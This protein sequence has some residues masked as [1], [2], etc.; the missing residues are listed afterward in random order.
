MQ[1][2]ITRFVSLLGSSLILLLSIKL[3]TPD[4][5][6]TYIVNLGLASLF[7]WLADFGLG[8]LALMS[9]SR[10]EASQF[11]VLLGLKF[12]SF[13]FL[14]SIT[15]FILNFAGLPKFESVIYI[16]MAV[17]VMT[18]TLVSVRQITCDWRTGF[19]IQA[20]KKISQ[21]ALLF[22]FFVDKSG[23]TL[24]S[25][26]MIILLPSLLIILFDVAHL[27]P[28]VRKFPAST[29]NN[30]TKIWL[31]GGGTALAN[32]DT[33][34]ISNLGGGSILPII[35][36]SRRFSNLVGIFGA[37]QAVETL[38]NF[39]RNK[40]ISRKRI[41]FIFTTSRRFFLLV[42]LMA[43]ASPWILSIFV[44]RQ[45]KPLEIAISIFVI[46]SAGLGF[47]TASLNAVLISAHKFRFAALSTYLLNIYQNEKNIQSFKI[48]KH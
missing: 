31:Q 30:A 13:F 19:L 11:R 6:D 1:T 41:S 8:N 39:S 29:F 46:L 12:F 28:L 3:L 10:G 14:L 34:L 27:Q 4:D 36:V 40:E 23:L 16:A 35:I 17:D 22:V 38:K 42:S 26:G 32:I 24:K 9:A 37:N 25:F 7:V 2:I 18:D 48:I 45:P 15:T 43:I 44:G 47:L 33:W 5:L 21:V 20:S